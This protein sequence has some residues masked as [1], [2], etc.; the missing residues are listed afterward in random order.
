MYERIY[1]K[2][3][4]QA[5]TQEVG[6]H[7]DIVFTV[8]AGILDE[9]ATAG[10]KIQVPVRGEEAA[11]EK[12][13]GFEDDK[14]AD[15]GG[16]GSVIVGGKDGRQA[17][18]K[19]ILNDTKRKVRVRANTNRLATCNEVGDPE[20]VGKLPVL[21]DDVDMVDGCK[22]ERLD[23][24]EQRGVVDKDRDQGDFNR[25]SSGYFVAGAI[26]SA[27]GGVDANKLMGVLVVLVN[28]RGVWEDNSRGNVLLVVEVRERR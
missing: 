19:T 14:G 22:P 4:G 27:M 17:S 16:L 8:E 10:P 9:N 11:I 24:G 28:A 1:G 18:R 25:K 21:Q 15:E 3:G 13:E 26:L 5:I 12:V 2:T 23:S 6:V 20:V 7:P